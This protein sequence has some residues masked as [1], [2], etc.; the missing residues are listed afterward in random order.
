MA[1]GVG[2]KRL[3]CYGLLWHFET[4]VGVVV[5]MLA[6]Y[7]GDR[8]S[9][10]YWPRIPITGVTPASVIVKLTVVVGF[11]YILMEKNV[12]GNCKE[13][14]SGTG[15]SARMVAWNHFGSGGID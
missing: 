13:A 1:R 2:S 11:S 6:S 12:L 4:S 8:A 5:S 7:R 9:I 15:F 14:E 3:D 10:G